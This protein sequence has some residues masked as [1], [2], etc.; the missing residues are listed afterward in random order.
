[1][2]PV[3]NISDSIL[4]RSE[5]TMFL[6]GG[7]TD[8]SVLAHAPKG[9]EGEGFYTVVFDPEEGRLQKLT[10]SKV[11]TNPAFIMKHPELDIVY[12]TTEVITQDG[13][14]VLVG[15]L[16]TEDGSVDV[17]DRKRVHGRSTCHISW[18]VSRSHLIAVSYWDSKITTFQVNADGSLEDASEVYSDPGCGYVDTNNPDRWEHLAH[19]QRWPHLHQVNMDP[20]TRRMF[21]VPDLG[22]DMIQF[23]NITQGQ[24]KHLGSHQLRRG[25]G[26][27]HLEFS[28]Q[29][30]MVYVCGELDNTVTVLRYNPEMVDTVLSGGYLEDDDTRS[31]VLTHVQTIS[32]VP[33]DIETKST[34]AEMR[35]HPSGRFLYVGNRGHNSIAIYKTSP[36]TGT[37]TLVD[38]QP[39][40]GAF[41]RHFNFDQTGQFLMVG[42][43]ASDNLVV[44]S[45]LDTGRLKM[46]DMMENV[47]SIV[48][49]T[50]VSAAAE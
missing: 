12:M 33:E 43:H 1:M 37:L 5:K 47:P 17:I 21:L 32:S 45:I 41:P 23:F 46:V 14:E 8:K 34:I 36:D 48:W 42:N 27:R 19:R 28:K 10:S 2:P 31:S 6:M 11:E 50:P 49:I 4:P 38:I 22:R 3:P 44:F 35:L 39:S 26:P 30:K 25:T 40:L 20:Y 29:Q 18:D 24:V 7:Y 16:N 13:S 9:G 15:K